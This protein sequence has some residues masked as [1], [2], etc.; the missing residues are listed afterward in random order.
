MR[1]HLNT[2]TEMSRI[3]SVLEE[4][5]LGNDFFFLD[6]RNSNQVKARQKHRKSSA[7]AKAYIFNCF[8]A[9]NVAVFG[10]VS[11]GQSHRG[12]ISY[13]QPSAQFLCCYKY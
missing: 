3:P 11:T 5:Q 4:L 10:S 8:E 2:H 9:E 6:A 1:L 13:S 7:Q 12:F